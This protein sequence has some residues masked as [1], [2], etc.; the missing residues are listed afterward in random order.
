M[1]LAAGARDDRGLAEAIA[2]LGPEVHSIGDCDGVGYI[3]GAIL[4]GARAA[5]QI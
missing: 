1:I 3:E 5:R 4:D 2:D